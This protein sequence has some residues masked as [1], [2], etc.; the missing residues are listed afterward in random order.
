VATLADL[1]KKID[2]A[3]KG[4]AAISTNQHDNLRRLVYGWFNWASAKCFDDQ[5]FTVTFLDE[6]MKASSPMSKELV[7]FHSL[8]N[9]DPNKYRLKN[10]R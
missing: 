9:G 3:T 7:K 6:V 2:L 8:Q 1:K 4:H 10:D 5:Q